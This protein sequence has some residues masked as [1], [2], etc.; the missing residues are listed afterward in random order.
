MNYNRGQ[1]K[2]SCP[3]ISITNSILYDSSVHG[4]M[5]TLDP[6]DEVGSWRCWLLDNLTPSYIHDQWHW[7]WNDLAPEEGIGARRLRH[8][9]TCTLG[10]Q[11]N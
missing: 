10:I 1:I 4:R 9:K 3:R 5:S 8:L 6:V 2:I 11:R 7:L